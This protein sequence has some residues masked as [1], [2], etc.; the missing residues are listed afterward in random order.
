MHLLVTALERDLKRFGEPAHESRLACGPGCGICCVL[1]VSVLF[2]EAVAI[3]WYVRRRL[4]DE[5][6]E[7]LKDRL[8]RLLVKTRW[9]DDEERL[10]LRESCG[11]LDAD[12]KCLIHAVRPLLCRSITSLDGTTCHDAV[13]S[14]PLGESP[15]VLMNLFQKEFF[16]TVYEGLAQGLAAVGWDDRPWQLT[17]AIHK[18]LNDETLVGRFLDGERVVCQ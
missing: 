10:F 16:E 15:V 14:M 18:L 11:F 7:K 3:A 6:I 12:G 2:P 17:T 9:L 13:V 4:S 5:A 1:N 8:Y